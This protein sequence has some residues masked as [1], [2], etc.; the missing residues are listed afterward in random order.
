[1]VIMQ[2]I[3]ILVPT[4]KGLSESTNTHRDYYAYGYGLSTV[5]YV[6]TYARQSGLAED[7]PVNEMIV[8]HYL[9]LGHATALY[10]YIHI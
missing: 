6:Y 8:H 9:K 2:E 1:M 5:T 10:M 7:A 3:D 4:I